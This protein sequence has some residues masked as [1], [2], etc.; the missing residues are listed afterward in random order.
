MKPVLAWLVE[1]RLVAW[2]LGLLVLLAGLRAQPFVP[3][4]PGL[5]LDPVAVDALPDLGENQQIVFTDWPGRS[6]QDVEQQITAPLSSALL[7]LA[8]VRSVRGTSM[9]GFSTIAVVFEDGADFYASRT[10][11]AERL[12]S[13]PVDLLPPGVRPSLGP[14]ATGLGQV[15]AY[16]LEGQDAQGRTVGGFDPDELRAVQDWTVR[17]GL[18][19]V[20][21]VSEVAAV[22]GMVREVQ[23]DVEP[24]RLRAAGVGVE[25]LAEAIETSNLDVGLRS[26]ERNGVELQVRSEGFLESLHDLEQAVVAWREGAPLRVGD[27]ARVRLGPAL[28]QGALDDEGAPA[29]GGIVVARHGANP[30]EVIAAL[31]AR[32]AELEPS[33]PRRV[34][35]DGTEAR[36]RLVPFYDR[37]QLIA[38]TL[39]TLAQALLQQ[40]LITVIVVLVMLRNLRGSLLIAGLL[41]LSVL[42][43]FAV[44]KLAGVQ[45]NVMALAGIAVAIGT[46]VDIGI[47]VVE[48]MHRA[49]RPG[50]DAAARARAVVEAAAEVGPAVLTSVLTTVVSFLPVLGLTAGEQRLFLP[51]VLTKSFAMLLALGLALLVLPGLGALLL[52]AREERPSALTPSPAAPSGGRAAGVRA[53]RTRGLLDALLVL[54]LGLL[55]V[56]S[57]LP[58]GEERGLP[59]NLLV[60]GL[61]LVLVLGGLRLFERAYP[62]I[63]SLALAHKAAFLAL[64]LGLVLLALLALRDLGREYL[65]PFD[66][67][68]FLYMPTTAPHA[69][70]G[71]AQALLSAMDA[72]IARVPEVARVVGKLGRA[73]SALDPAPVAMFETVVLLRPEFGRDA[74]GRRV[75]QWRPEI[76]G[77]RD[78]WR[79]IE[80]AAALPGLTGAPRLAPIQARQVML[81]SGMRAPLGVKVQGPRLDEVEAFAL[82]LEE[83][84][85]AVPELR[86]GSVFADRQLGLPTLSIRLDREALARHGLRLTE[87]QRTLELALAGVELTRTVE[88]RQRVPVRLRYARE[89]RG[90]VEDVG[91]VLIST[92]SGAQLPLRAVARLVEERGPQMIRSEDTALQSQVVFDAA[93]GV[94]ERR[95]VQ[96][97]ARAIEE[98]LREGALVQPEGVSFRFAGTW[99]Q[100]LR[101]EDRLAVL[102]PLAGLL[103][104]LLIYLQFGR[105]STA[106]IIASGVLVAGSGAVLLLWLYGRPG[107]L[108]LEVGG[109][110][111][112]ELFQVGTVNLSVAVW[113]GMIALLGIATDDG[114]V[115]STWLEQSLRARPPRSRE[116][117]RARTL[118]AGERRLRACLM[119]SATTL[120][121]LLPVITSP[122]RGADVMLPLALPAL[123]GM[124]VALLTLFVV[125]VLTAARE[126]RGLPERV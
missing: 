110:D 99:E 113:V 80:R 38:E 115:L 26:L 75:R 107:F 121:A 66:E 42:G 3:R 95:A 17:L 48:N 105:V 55:L 22:G 6:P 28:R 18:Q 117:V 118:E 35:S 29:V 15:F 21:G 40:V 43:C 46:M 101:A 74:Q 90:A 83:R 52:R 54:V 1:H 8:R 120:L 56:L 111:L 126:E 85:R 58:L 5:P 76:R 62:R 53:R 27:L 4:I 103:V 60:A 72:E 119:T 79:E 69:S 97:A 24:E 49:L 59:L 32:I 7:G 86:P 91:A 36:V 64:P 81:Q 13:L 94:D 23:V 51:L 57:W 116:E 93:P 82:A 123:G 41:P 14:D 88:G 31:K 106:G 33:L 114:V 100:A 98:G 39:Q 9:P 47:V 67:G 102:V 122:G 77:P 20:P 124:S 2:L 109:V 61:L 104:F 25:E 73:E 68:A 112:R 71:E 70:I 78:I 30:M 87:V 11:I 12:A 16:T 96:A 65:P 34:L 84:L 92:P 63:L 108:A 89:A 50:M 10:R 44:M 125:P 19:A 45:A 37:S